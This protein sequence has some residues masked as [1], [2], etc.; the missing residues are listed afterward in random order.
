MEHRIGSE[1]RS[2]DFRII[3][4]ERHQSLVPESNT[5]VNILRPRRDFIQVGRR[6]LDAMSTQVR[7]RMLTWRNTA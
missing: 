6:T 7:A 3:N 2:S 4:I 5:E 1:Q